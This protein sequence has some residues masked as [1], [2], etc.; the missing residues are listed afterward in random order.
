MAARQFI[1]CFCFQDFFCNTCVSI[2]LVHKLSSSSR[3]KKSLVLKRKRLKCPIDHRLVLI[4][5][6]NRKSTGMLHC[7][8]HGKYPDDNFKKRVRWSK[9]LPN[10]KR[11]ILLKINWKS[12]METCLF[13]L[14]CQWRNLA[15]SVYIDFNCISLTV[16]LEQLRV[17][18]LKFV[19][20][21]RKE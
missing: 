14:K 17:L 4:H 6:K 21:W 10:D 18:F 11:S 1:L 19:K 13:M 5:T 12:Q 2:I 7:K 15:Y 20:D 16:F 8:R 9:W 3:I